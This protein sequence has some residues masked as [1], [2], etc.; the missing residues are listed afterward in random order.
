VPKIVG[1]TRAKA[2]VSRNRQ[3]LSH[4]W[5]DKVFAKVFAEVLAESHHNF[6]KKKG[7][8]KRTF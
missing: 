7:Y 5:F 3:G 4:G 6:I 2:R 1:D 8:S